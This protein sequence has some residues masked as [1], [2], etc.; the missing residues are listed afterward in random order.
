MR[1]I[2]MSQ[3]EYEEEVI[4]EYLKV[5]A[6]TINRKITTIRSSNKASKK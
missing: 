6:F 2:R 5:K 4:S 1:D 3:I